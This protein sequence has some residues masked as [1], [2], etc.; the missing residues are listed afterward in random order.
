MKTADSGI[1]TIIYIVIVVIVT[2]I[3]AL[4]KRAKKNIVNE[5]EQQHKPVKSWEEILKETLDVPGN[6]DP[7]AQ[8]EPA[9]PE[10][11]VHKYTEKMPQF[12]T[13]E[14][15]VSDI[16]GKDQISAKHG[17]HSI[18]GI[19]TSEIGRINEDS[20]IGHLDFDIRKAVIFSEILNKKYS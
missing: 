1:G 4:N 9:I 11:R 7:V 12:Q 20:G 3:S 17:Y 5:G 16:H 13:N 14:K 8:T 6:D 2:I 10:I 15:S 19:I 18:E